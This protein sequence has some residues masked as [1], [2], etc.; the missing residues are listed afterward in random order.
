METAIQTWEVSKNFRKN[1]EIMLSNRPQ[2]GWY[3]TMTHYD[4]S[5]IS[6]IESPD[7]VLNKLNEKLSSRGVKFNFFFYHL[8]KPDYDEHLGFGEVSETETLTRLFGE[9]ASKIQEI[10]SDDAITIVFTGNQADGLKINFRSA[11]I[12]MHRIS[13][14]FCD[15]SIYNYVD[16][17]IFLCRVLARKYYGNPNYW[18]EFFFIDRYDT[19]D[20][21]HDASFL[22]LFGKLLCTTKAARDGNLD[23]PYEWIHEVF[24]QYMMTGKVRFNDLPKHI[25][26]GEGLSENMVDNTFLQERVNKITREIFPRYI[27]KR[28]KRFLDASKGK[29]FVV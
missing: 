11:W 26:L 24:A 6:V 7:N 10:T 4:E 2:H 18:N 17:F 15:S 1:Q 12:L 27:E 28:F 25:C 19:M 22:N 21:D 20:T 14:A 3:K 8:E 16:R 13:H 29:I 5:D 9:D 23:R